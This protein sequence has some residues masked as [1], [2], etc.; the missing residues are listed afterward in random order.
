MKKIFLIVLI[1]A[2]TFSCNVNMNRRVKGNGNLTTETRD[3]DEVTRIKIRGGINVELVPGNSSTVKVEADEN[4]QKHIITRN[5]DGWLVVKTKDNVNLKSSNPIKVYVSADMINTIN[6][7]G[8]GNLLGK[9]KFTGADK[10]EID[11]AG[12]GDVDM[13]VNTPRVIVD[14]AGSGNVIL[15]GETKDARINIAG[16][17]NYNA[18]DLMTETTDIDIA[19]SGDAK[20]HADVSL[21]ADVFGSGSIYYRGKASVKTNSTGSGKVKPMD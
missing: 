12:S 3:V 14:I 4:L 5:E 15:S 13:D 17:G 10:L 9:G 1:T 18:A 16:S 21:K 2:V 8:S 19:G 20:V 6:I 7:A 11:V